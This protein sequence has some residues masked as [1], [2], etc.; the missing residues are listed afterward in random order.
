MIVSFIC[1]FFAVCTFILG[2]V[3][4]V[5]NENFSDAFEYEICTIGWLIASAVW[6][7]K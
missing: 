4:I 6:W 5:K 2:I 1:M 7:D 3:R